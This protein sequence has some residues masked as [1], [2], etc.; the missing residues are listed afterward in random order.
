MKRTFILLLA[1]LIWLNYQA[2]GQEKPPEKTKTP[3]KE[4]KDYKWDAS[5]GVNNWGLGYS[6]LML[7]Y[8]PKLKGAYRFSIENH[9]S[10]VGKDHYYADSS[11][12]AVAHRIMKNFQ[13]VTS[14]GYEFRRNK[15]RHQIFYGTDLQF[16]FRT[17]DDRMRDFY[18]NRAFA[19][20][21]HP[22]VGIKYRI[23]NRLSVSG[24]TT[25]LF[26]YNIEQAFGSSKHVKTSNRSY[27]ST[28]YNAIQIINVTYHL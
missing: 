6:N 19:F 25:L 24:E 22:F 9:N 5:I 15:G 16:S 20:G 8:A 17:S 27:F 7:R 28:Y 18:P 21:I 14:L 12:N 3:V 4:F 23:L 11:G 10:S 26:D 1:G 2:Q 13:A